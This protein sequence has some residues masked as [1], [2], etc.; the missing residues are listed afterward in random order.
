MLRKVL[1]SLTDHSKRRKQREMD[2]TIGT[3]NMRK[4]GFPGNRMGK[5]WTDLDRGRG[6]WRAI[7]KTI[8]EFRVP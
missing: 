1:R 4:M 7:A 2:V 3:W 5:A 6:K 8:M